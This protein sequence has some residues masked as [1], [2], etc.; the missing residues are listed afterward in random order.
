MTL[1]ANFGCF[2]CVQGQ[3]ATL[4]PRLGLALDKLGYH[5]S[6]PMKAGSHAASESPGDTNGSS[7]LPVG[8]TKP[9]SGGRARSNGFCQS[10][11]GGGLNEVRPH[12]QGRG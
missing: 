8:R 9:I 3:I 4:D 6:L 11:A 2:G 1:R 5:A 12:A 10:R 7:R